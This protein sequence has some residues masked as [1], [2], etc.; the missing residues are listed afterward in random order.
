MLETI[1]PLIL[2]YNEAPN[3][4][5]TLQQLTWAQ[6]IIVIDSY[7]TNETLEILSPTLKSNSSN[8]SLIPILNNGIM[9]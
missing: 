1:T 5:R 4:D 3:I 9:V 6:K 8:A 7:S 2:T